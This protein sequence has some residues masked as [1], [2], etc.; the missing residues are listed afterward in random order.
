LTRAQVEAIPP[1]RLHELLQTT[2]EDVLDPDAL[3]DTRRRWEQE[4][5]RI[6]QLLRRLRR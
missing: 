4:R 6:E 5:G 2:L 3:T 1:A